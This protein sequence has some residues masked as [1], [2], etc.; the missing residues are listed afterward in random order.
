VKKFS[1]KKKSINRVEFTSSLNELK[2]EA[3]NGFSEEEVQMLVDALTNIEGLGKL[4]CYYTSF[5]LFLENS[6][7]LWLLVTLTVSLKFVLNTVIILRQY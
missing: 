5:K 7:S 2:R 4:L 3:H 6:F 1:G